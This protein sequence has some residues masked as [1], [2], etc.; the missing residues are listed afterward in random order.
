MLF[1][2]RPRLLIC[3]LTASVLSGCASL[4]QSSSEIEIYHTN[5]LHS[6]FAGSLKGQACLEEAECTGGYGAIKHYVDN[7][8]VQN[9]NLMFMDAGDQFQGSYL[10]IKNKSPFVRTIDNLM[11]YDFGTIGNHEFD[12]GCEKL[13][14]FIDSANYPFLAANLKPEDSCPLKENKNISPYAI[15]NY[16]G[17]DVGIIGLAN[18]LV[19]KESSACA[20]TKFINPTKAVKQAVSELQRRGVQIIIVL[21]H[22][23]LPFDKKLA[24]AVTGVDV[25]VG[26]HSHKYLGPNSKVGPYPMVLMA[27]DG[28]PVLIVTTPGKA[29]HLGHLKVTFD[30]KGVPSQWS[31]EP[32]KLGKAGGNEEIS[33]VINENAQLL[34]EQGSRLVGENKVEAL[35]GLDP[36]REGECL[37]ASL[38]TQA[39]LDYGKTFGA[40]IA[41]INGG[42]FRNALPVG[43]IH[44]RDLDNLQPFNDI[45]VIRR[46][47]GKQLIEAVEHG[48]SDEDGIG[49]RILHAAGL[50]YTYNPKAPEGKRVI[51]VEVRNAQGKWEKPKANQTYVVIT[52]TF[53]AHGGDGHKALGSGKRVA[54]PRKATTE[55][56]E[57]W[58]KKH[59]PVTNAPD[60]SIRIAD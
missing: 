31:G 14:K 9:P 35:D 21:S 59:S 33:K 46:Y 8:K 23:G 2:D 19:V 4:H 28:Q 42:S 45:T 47:T 58:L 24:Q 6:H 7:A 13:A 29:K 43:T 36:C 52:N 51:S 17:Q 60:A 25:I 53:L 57:E 37:S 27:P 38:V 39:M 34:K 49:P 41:L 10:Y 22:M 12:E 32:I 26:G 20:H 55:I 11:G 30:E 48:V 50:R 44:S 16:N 3:L 1:C 40:Q 18:P 54:N 15:R 5:D 56:F